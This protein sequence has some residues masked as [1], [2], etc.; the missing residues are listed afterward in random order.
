MAKGVRQDPLEKLLAEKKR[1]EDEKAAL[2]AKANPLAEQIAIETE[3]REREDNEYL[4]A[5]ARL[6]LKNDS[7]LK[8]KLAAHANE[9][10]EH[11]KHKVKARRSLMRTLGV[12]PAPEDHSSANVLMKEA[13][14]DFVRTRK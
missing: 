5:V 6:L 12:L 7:G 4:G 11:A 3:K 1:L 2:N 10:I 14:R 8:P 13:G 9:V